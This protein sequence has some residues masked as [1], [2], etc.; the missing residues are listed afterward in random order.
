MKKVCTEKSK[1]IRDAYLRRQKVASYAKSL[2]K[3]RELTKNLRSD[4]NRMP[5]SAQQ[6]MPNLT[7]A[8]CY[9][10]SLFQS[11]LH[12]PRFVNWIIDSHQPEDCVSD[13]QE[14]CVSCSARLLT[15]EYWRGAQGKPEL[16]KVLRGMNDLFKS[17]KSHFNL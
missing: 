15:L 1:S 10:L 12:Q 17:C 5:A 7:G 6:G 4:S 13:S 2:K 14:Q 3:K 9:R 11:L 16:S 8:L